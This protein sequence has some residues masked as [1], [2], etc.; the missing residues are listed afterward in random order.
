MTEQQL[1][2]LKEKNPIV[3]VAT[4]LG[5]SVKNRGGTQAIK[6]FAH[7]DSSP[8]LVF[9]PDIGRFECKGCSVKGDVID[10][11]QRFRNIS[12]EAAIDYLDP[13]IK[14]K[15]K[16]MIKMS[17]EKYLES[18]GLTAETLAKFNIR[19]GKYG[20]AEVVIIPLENGNKY[21]KMVQVAPKFVQDAGTNGSLYK[22]KPAQKKVIL[23]EGELD[24]V[25]LWQETGY[26]VWSGTSGASTFLEKWRKD[27]EAV[28][29]VYICYDNDDAGREGSERVISVLGEDRCCRI[30]LPSFA[31]DITEYFQM[32]STK[33]DFDELL[34]GA[35]PAKKGIL[36]FYD[37]SNTSSFSVKTGFEAIDDKTSFYSGNA[38]LIAGA[39]KSGKSAL[40]FQIVNHILATGERVAFCNTELS[41]KE[42]Y[43]RV[44]GS[45]LEKEYLSVT[46]KDVAG[47]AEKYEN[48]FTYTGIGDETVVVEGSVNFTAVMGRLKAAAERGVRVFFLDNVSTFADSADIDAGVQ[49]WQ[50]MGGC[51][52]K[53]KEFSKNNNVVLFVV[54]H[55]KDNAIEHESI[56][57]VKDMIKDKNPRKIFSDTVAIMKRPTNASLYGGMRAIGQFSGTILIW[58]PWQKFSDGDFSK[59]SLIMLESFRSAAPAV[60]LQAIFRGEIP[61]F[62]PVETVEDFYAEEADYGGGSL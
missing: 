51:M 13:Q 17:A 29:K 26:P 10:L 35:I 2:E 58:R 57:R 43:E 27:F 36:S 15:K 38:Y 7:E 47:W 25:R 46:R 49:G 14:A 61:R 11:I 23:T 32:G 20:S 33:K 53:L 28:E 41:I 21:R 40:C 6:C 24:A 56:S 54:N 37:D 5:L 34:K 55:A 16:E 42:L 12:F 45:Y 48:S 60:E 1:I 50:V 19:A 62:N 3:D 8:S 9:Y 30:I 39:E 31:K 4:R 59:W 44:V 18:R 22:T 52:A